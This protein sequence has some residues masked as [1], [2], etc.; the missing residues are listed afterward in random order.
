MLLLSYGT[1]ALRLALHL[2]GVKPVD[3]DLLSPL[4]FVATAHAV[5]HLAAVPH[6]VDVELIT[7]GMDSCA[8]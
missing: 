2:V 5:M 7:L 1:F 8:P 6:F 3:E 4:S